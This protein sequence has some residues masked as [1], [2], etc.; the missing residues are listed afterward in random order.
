M[1]DS[2][3]RRDFLATCALAAV[4]LPAV[5]QSAAQVRQRLPRSAKPLAL[6]DVEL[7]PSLFRNAVD[8]NRRYVLSL[9]PDR[10]LHNF[11]TGAGLPPRAERYGGW[12]GD[13]IAGHTLG[14]YLSALALLHAQAAD[15]ETKR[16]AQYVVEELALVQA[17]RGD[18]YVAGLTRK[19]KDGSIVDGQEIFPEIMRGEISATGFDL[20]GAWSPLYTIHKLFAGLLDVHQHCALDSALAVAVQLG[21]YFAK[22]FAALDDTQ[23][24]AMLACE[25][26]G[27]NESFAELGARTGEPHWITLAERIRDTRVLEPLARQEDRLAHHHSNTQV[28][29]LVGLARLYELTGK[30]SYASTARFFWERVTQHH[31]YVIGGNSDRE[32]FFAPDAISKYV[33]EQTC[34]H[35]NTYNMLRL[36]RH[37]F[38]WQPDARWFDFYERAHLNHVMSQQHPTTG[39]FT[40]MTPLMAGAVREFSTPTDSFWCCVGSGMESHAKHADSVFWEGDNTL[41]VNLYIPATARWRAQGATVRLQSSYPFTGSI[42]LQVEQLARPQRFAIA[43]RIP[44][45]ATESQ[46]TVNGKAVRVERESGYAI[47]SRRWRAGDVIAL[48][49]PHRLRIEPTPDDPTTIAV[50]HGPLV[51]AADLG[52]GPNDL[53]RLAPA[54]VADDVLATF[55]AVPNEAATF[56]V[57]ASVARPEALRFV[58]FFSQYERRSAV[59]VR[60]FTAEDWQAE[61]DARQAAAE[62]ERELAVRSIDVMAL[63]ESEAEREHQLTSAISY[64]VSYRGVNGRDARSGGFFEFDLN[65]QPGMALHAT[66]WGD[67]RRREF[68][69]LIDGQ[70]LARQKLEHDHPGQ[71]F[72]VQYPIPEALIRGK[73]KVRVRFEPP[74][75]NT[76]GPVFG[77]RALRVTA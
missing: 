24:Q 11:R 45:W 62:R 66:Y 32:Y 69:V 9:D 57:P 44:R 63:G 52:P 77:V 75:K 20:N 47:V 12:E 41:F 72:S 64:A 36:T 1:S 67:E 58:P 37:L 56:D 73:S 8:V 55:A 30:E 71:F 33:T 48:E 74:A 38:A 18:G 61:L 68:D 35:C 76:A 15:A 51:L 34:E 49:L 17:K 53:T 43:L 13:T 54:L 10:L 65:V 70:W 14:H 2:I 59:Y 21:N 22:V 19:R 46:V 31:S 25:Y 42:S 5:S 60:R 39:M 27:I 50:L 6:A 7:L 4:T 40:Y 29:K 26:G 28:P 23:L 16:R 3:R